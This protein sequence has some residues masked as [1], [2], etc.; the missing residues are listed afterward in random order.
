MTVLNPKQK[1]TK[2]DLLSTAECIEL[3]GEPGVGGTAESQLVTFNA[4]YKMRLYDRGQAT[5]VTKVR[6]HVKISQLAESAL[7]TVLQHYGAERIVE[8]GLDVYGGSYNAR[9]MRGGTEWSKH[10]FGIAFDFLPLE[11]ALKTRLANSTFGKPEYKAWLDIW[12]Q[13]GFVNLGRAADYDPMHFEIA[14][15]A[16]K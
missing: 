12:Q 16:V 8:L 5:N 4:P 14:R 10:A 3:F 1:P 15:F 13:H 9:Q 11:N 6:C 7:I 2:A